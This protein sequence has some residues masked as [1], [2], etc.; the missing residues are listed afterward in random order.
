MEFVT[1]VLIIFMTI[2][3]IANLAIETHRMFNRMKQYFR[4][5]LIRA[6][7]QM[8]RFNVGRRD[9]GFR[10]RANRNNLHQNVGW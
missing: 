2:I 7:R 9:I 8:N 3:G 4:I 1:V 6:Q 5:E 10:A